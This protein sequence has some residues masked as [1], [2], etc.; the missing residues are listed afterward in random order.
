MGRV[1]GVVWY[2]GVGRGGGGYLLVSDGSFCM[3]GLGDVGRS[4]TRRCRDCGG[5]VSCLETTN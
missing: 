1:G 5:R 2:W 3:C 4:M